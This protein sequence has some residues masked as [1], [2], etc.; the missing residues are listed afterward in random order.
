ATFDVSTT[1]QPPT[2]TPAVA[3]PSVVTRTTTAL[4]T[5]GSDDQGESGLTYTWST[6]SSPPAAVSFSS[7]G[8]N[9]SKNTTATF[10][11]PG[12][13]ALRVTARDAQGLAATS[14]VDVTV[15]ATFAS[16]GVTPA[17]ATIAGGATQQFTASGR[18]Q[19]G[20]A[21]VNQPAFTWSTSGGG[22]VDGLGV[23]SAG[24]TSGGPYSV[25]A[26]SGTISGTASVTISSSPPTTVSFGETAV[27]PVDD[28]ENGNLLLAQP[29]SLTRTLT[30]RSLSFYVAT[31]AG[32]L[33]LGIYDAT[34]P[35]G[36]P[37]AKRA[38]TN[39]I[40][41]Q[42]AGW[43]TGNVISPV[44]LAPG[45]YW[46]AYLPSDNGLHFRKQ[47]NSSNAKLVAFP[48]GPLPATFS[49]RPNTSTSHW[50]LF[51]SGTP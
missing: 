2:L 44:T 41:I 42:S 13:Y 9:A 24:M 50:S 46:L 25:T 29:T 34:G 6:R 49:T 37:G 21:L 16:I 5:S 51:A 35:A 19:F 47:P 36:G 38:E 26:R 27:L 4:S 40:V 15:N 17:S 20:G 14:D 22:T 32:K 10:A 30:I 18:D 11:A 39:E 33:R 12:T 43:A 3:N 31:P 28:S 1:D 48:Y 45:T 23:Y 7:N 8:V